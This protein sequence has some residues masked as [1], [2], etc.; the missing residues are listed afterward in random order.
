VVRVSSGG[1]IN[2]RPLMRMKRKIIQAPMLALPNLHNPFEVETYASG[3]A[4]GEVLMQG[5]RMYA[6]ILKYFMG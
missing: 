4:M 2:R 6:I 3:Y 5:G 1:R